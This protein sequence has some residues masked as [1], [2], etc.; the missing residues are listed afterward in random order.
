LNLSTSSLTFAPTRVGSTAAYQ[1]VTLTNTGNQ[2]LAILQIHIANTTDFYS[3]GIRDDGCGS[4]LPAGGSCTFSVAFRPT[5]EGAITAKVRIDD[6]DASWNQEV[7]L[8]G[9]GK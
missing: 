9:T 1:P 7:D 5:R 4:T 6:N 8:S 2:T 3:W